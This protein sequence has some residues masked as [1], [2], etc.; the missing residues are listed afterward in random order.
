MFGSK[1]Y[2]GTKKEAAKRRLEAAFRR[3]AKMMERAGVP[4]LFAQIRYEELFSGDKSWKDLLAAAKAVKNL[5]REGV[6]MFGVD[7]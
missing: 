4:L 3:R 2:N 1:K 7:S 5:H 6:S